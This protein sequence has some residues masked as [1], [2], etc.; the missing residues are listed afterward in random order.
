MD[1]EDD[2]QCN[3]SP[4]SP[5]SPSSSHGSPQASIND[6]SAHS[7]CS[8]GKSSP[9]SLS[10][11]RKES[12]SP[13]SSLPAGSPAAPSSPSSADSVPMKCLLCHRTLE[14]TRF[15]QCPSTTSHKFCFGCSR[16]SI[17]K[18]LE[19]TSDV[20]CPSGMKCLVAGS[21]TPWAFMEQEISTI[22]QTSA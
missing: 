17:K 10:P 11:T 19:G 16:D 7:P 3:H 5:K 13:V 1:G 9:S 22:L 6:Y 18:Q 21:T 4:K 14:D 8:N 15:V 20:Y 2:R 12:A